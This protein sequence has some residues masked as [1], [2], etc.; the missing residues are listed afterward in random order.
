MKLE[1]T[2]EDFRQF[3]LLN[4]QKME[5][6][7][8]EDLLSDWLQANWEVIIESRLQE[9]KCIS[10]LLDIYGPGADCNRSSSRVSLPHLLPSCS[11][12]VQSSFALHSFGT[13]QNGYFVQAPPFDYVKGENTKSEVVLRLNEAQFAIGPTYDSIA[14]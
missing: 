14:T 4:Y 2:L 3:L 8:S 10:G 7:L 9:A 6:L 11:I 5:E 12:H 13:M 1:D